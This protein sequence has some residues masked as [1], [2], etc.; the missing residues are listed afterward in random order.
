[1]LE[2]KS[3]GVREIKFVS[4]LTTKVLQGHQLNRFGVSQKLKTP[5][6][7]CQRID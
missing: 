6:Q 2:G 5:G 4:K 7:S 3:K 1:M